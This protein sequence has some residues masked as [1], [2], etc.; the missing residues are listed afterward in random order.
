MLDTAKRFL[1]D[2][3]AALAPHVREGTR[4]VGI[5]P[6]CVPAFRDELPNGTSTSRA[7]RRAAPAAPRAPGPGW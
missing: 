7:G 2:L 5:E 6:S 3:V 4:V 1:G